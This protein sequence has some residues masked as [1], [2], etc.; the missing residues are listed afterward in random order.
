MGHDHGAGAGEDRL[1]VFDRIRFLCAVHKLRS[2]LHVKTPPDCPT[3]QKP[4]CPRISSSEMRA[5]TG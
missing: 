5:Q 2:P 1:Q 4:M 3:A